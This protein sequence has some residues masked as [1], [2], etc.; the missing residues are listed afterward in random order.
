MSQIGGP[1]RMVGNDFVVRTKPEKVIT[2]PVAPAVIQ[3][4]S[5]ENESYDVPI[6]LTPVAAHGISFGKCLAASTC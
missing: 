6:S 1:T 2:S 4:T 5:I 3:V